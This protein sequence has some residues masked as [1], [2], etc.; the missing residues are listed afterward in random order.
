M[1][2]TGQFSYRRASSN[3]CAWSSATRRT[4]RRR[5]RTAALSASAPLH[6]P[7]RMP[8][9]SAFA[10][11]S[12]SSPGA[13][14]SAPDRAQP[15]NRARAGESG[16]TS[17]AMRSTTTDASTTGTAIL[18]H[19]VAGG[20][21]DGRPD[22]PGLPVIDLSQPR[23]E[24]VQGHRADGAGSHL[25]RD[26]LQVHD[27]YVVGIP[28]FGRGQPTGPDPAADGLRR[29]A[30]APGRFPHRYFLRRGH[31]KDDTTTSTTTTPHGWVG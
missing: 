30:G 4:G 14:S 29:P 16:P 22:P 12:Q 27:V 3:A 20:L 11:S 9:S 25:D 24:V 26:S 6:R 17:G 2:S 28:A 8:V 5:S 15:A 13:S 1:S 23:P 7:R 19:Q 21:A 18:D 10:V 31:V